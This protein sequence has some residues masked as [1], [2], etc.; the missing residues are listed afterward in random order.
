MLEDVI[1]L[2]KP[3][4]FLQLMRSL[5]KIDER[6][7]LKLCNT[8]GYF[9]LL[10]LRKSANM[11]FLMSLLGCSLIIP[12]FYMEGDTSDLVEVTKEESLFLQISMANSMNNTSVL[13]FVLAVT[14]TFAILAYFLLYQIC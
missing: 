11:F 12:V 8:D 2:E 5:Y 6:Y 10:F 1:F 7:L 4:N 3:K 9:Y 14:F 13:W